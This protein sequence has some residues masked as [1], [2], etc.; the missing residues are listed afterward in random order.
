MS[1]QVSNWRVGGKV[2]LNVYHHD[3]PMFQCHTPEDA[4]NIVHLLNLADSSEQTI[5]RLQEELDLKAQELSGQVDSDAW[6]AIIKYAYADG[7]DG[8]RNIYNVTSEFIAMRSERDELR[9]QLALVAMPTAE[10]NQTIQ[11]ERTLSDQLAAALDKTQ[12]DI[13]GYLCEAA[14]KTVE[15]RPPHHTICQDVQAAL[16][17]YAAS[18]AYREQ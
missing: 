14:W 6:K 5:Q 16:A 17:Q 18:R 2:P 12:A 15:G 4:A 11:Q 1:D 9:S 13:C 7:G 3:R 8:A 10:I